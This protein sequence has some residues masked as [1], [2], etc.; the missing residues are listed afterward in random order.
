M[1]LIAHIVGGFFSLVG[2]GVCLIVAFNW[3]NFIKSFK[4]V[5]RDQ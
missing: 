5:Y 2:L 1:T 3:R 4:E